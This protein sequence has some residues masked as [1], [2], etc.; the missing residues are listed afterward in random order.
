MARTAVQTPKPPV[1]E[2]PNTPVT[3]DEVL[4][5]LF[6]NPNGGLL[7]LSASSPSG[8]QHDW[9]FRRSAAS[10]KVARWC[11]PPFSP[12]MS[13]DTPSVCIAR[14]ADTDVRFSPCLYSAPTAAAPITLTHLWVSIPLRSVVHPTAPRFGRVIDTAAEAAAL[15]RLHALK[16]PPSLILNEGLRLTAIWPLGEVI[17]IGERS[18]RIERRLGDLARKLDGDRDVDPRAV[19]FPIPGTMCSNI[20]PTTPV[21]ATITSDRPVALEDF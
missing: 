16:I 1:V 14:N 9:Y 19:S 5:R 15:D 13:A 11:W 6:P 21:T 10:A 7:R 2:T 12:A 4:A 20:F 18:T 17:N 8:R 3:F